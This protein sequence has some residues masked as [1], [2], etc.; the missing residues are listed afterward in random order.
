MSVLDIESIRRFMVH[1]KLA[2]SC[3]VVIGVTS[4]RILVIYYMAVKGLSANCWLT[5]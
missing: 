2:L 1:V 3:L 4:L 5:D